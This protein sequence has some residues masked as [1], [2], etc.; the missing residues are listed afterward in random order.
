M[1]HVAVADDYA[2]IRSALRRFFEFEPGFSWAGEAADGEQAIRL[3]MTRH[4]DVLIL[5]LGMPG[6]GGLDALPRL[7][8]AAP[9]L[10]VVVFSA[11]PASAYARNAVALGTSNYLE[12]PS[13]LE[14]LAATVRNAM[15]ED[16]P[17]V[18]GKIARPD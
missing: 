17:R 2:Q 15:T 16:P 8:A 1:I 4:V 10:R 7:R 13:D 14:L 3:V 12:K 6:A 11:Y 5:D 18:S 9:Y